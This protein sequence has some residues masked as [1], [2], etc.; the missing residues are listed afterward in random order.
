MSRQQSE[1]FSRQEILVEQEDKSSNPYGN[2]GGCEGADSPLIKVMTSSKE[3]KF[4]KSNEGLVEGQPQV[5]YKSLKNIIG[6]Q[7]IQQASSEKD[8]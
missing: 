3:R 5:F 4:E 1:E 7:P 6:L 2:I 8:N